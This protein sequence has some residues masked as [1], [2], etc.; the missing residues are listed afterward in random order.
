MAFNILPI[1]QITMP[2]VK[3]YT[4]QICDTT[5]DHGIVKSMR[6]KQLTSGCPSETEQTMTQ[7]YGRWR[8]KVVRT[9]FI[10]RHHVGDR[11]TARMSGVKV[12]VAGRLASF[13]VIEPSE[14]L[15]LRRSLKGF[16]GEHRPLCVSKHDV[17]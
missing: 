16:V 2:K 14:E 6:V 8:S 15:Y 3:E 7:S 17:A 4:I 9:P 12:D 10:C 11:K 5:L 13:Q 1:N